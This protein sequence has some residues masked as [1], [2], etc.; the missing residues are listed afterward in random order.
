MSPAHPAGWESG[1]QKQNHLSAETRVKGDGLRLGKEET[2]WAAVYVLRVWIKKHGVPRRALHRLE[3]CV[4]AKSH[5]RRA[6]ARRGAGD[7]VRT[8]VSEAGHSDY[9]GQFAAGQG[10]R[11]TQ[12]RHAPGPA[13][14]EAAATRHICRNTIAALRA[15]RRSPKI[16]TGASRAR[17]NCV[18]SSAWR[19]CAA[20]ATIG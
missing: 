2:I 9:R 16:I 18:R 11:G 8:H 19:P 1:C 5:A 7:R 17:G 6:V 4:Q 20:S 14:Q 15:R 13:D 3:K 10:T 12:S